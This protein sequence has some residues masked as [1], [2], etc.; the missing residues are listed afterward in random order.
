VTTG[1]LVTLERLEVQDAKAFRVAA[2]VVDDLGKLD[3]LLGL[4]FLSRFDIDQRRDAIIVRAR[5]AR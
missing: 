1:P 3:G 4:S 5:K 2:V